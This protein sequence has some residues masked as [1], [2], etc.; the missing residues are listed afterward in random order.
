ML[1]DYVVLCDYYVAL[2]EVYTCVM[3][4]TWISIYEY[5]KI[6]VYEVMGGGGGGS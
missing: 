4:T 5:P 6:S 2:W 3:S 1:S